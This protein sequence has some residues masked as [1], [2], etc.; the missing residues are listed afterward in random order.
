[1]H[2]LSCRRP[3]GGSHCAAV[4]ELGAAGSGGRVRDAVPRLP[5]SCRSRV[6]MAARPHLVSSSTGALHLDVPR[7]C[8]ERR[9]HPSVLLPLCSWLTEKRTTGQLQSG[10]SGMPAREGLALLLQRQQQAPCQRNSTNSD[11]RGI[12]GDSHSITQGGSLVAGSL[13]VTHAPPRQTALRRSWPRWPAAET[14]RL[15][16]ALLC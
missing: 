16:L 4:C 7:A 14:L 10:P 13:E 15:C 5:S 9:P 2:N 6:R 3:L 1:M 12:R 8:R 11:G